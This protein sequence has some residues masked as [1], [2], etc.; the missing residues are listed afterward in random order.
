MPGDSAL[1]ERHGFELLQ[2][3][4]NDEDGDSE[5]KS[6]PKVNAPVSYVLNSIPM[7]EFLISHSLWPETEKLYGHPYEIVCVASNHRGSVLAAACIAKQAEH[8]KV[9]LWETGSMKEVARLGG[10]SLSVAQISFS[11]SD[12]Y[13]LTVSRD[14]S[15]CLYSN[16][17]GQYALI[18]SADKVHARI[19]WS[20]DW[21]HDDSY[22]VTGSR[23]KKI[24]VWNA[25][26]NDKFD[27]VCDSV[28]NFE[29]GVTAVAFAPNF[30]N[31]S[32][33]LLAI[34]FENGSIQLWTGFRD[35]LGEPLVWKV[36]LQIDDWYYYLEFSILFL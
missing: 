13:M 22:F 14:R 15:F 9:I 31:S 33:Y 32:C 28:L 17:S 16:V 20:C 35:K 6:Q 7:E 8:A 11:H 12:R 36:F 24:K 2:T 34:G 21:S 4:G 5:Y 10:H 19:I 3:F 23:D 26:S 1:P 29:V 18:H 27:S 25:P 30:I